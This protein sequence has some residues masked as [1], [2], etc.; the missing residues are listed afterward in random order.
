MQTSNQN[1]D[2]GL[3]IQSQ[4]GVVRHLNEES[5]ILA[6][7]ISRSFDHIRPR[8][9]PAAF[10]RRAGDEA[11]FEIAPGASIVMCWIPSGDFLMGSP[12]CDKYRSHWETQHRVIITKGFW[13]AKT[14]TTQAHWE[15]VMKSNPS[16]VKGSDLPVAGVSWLEICGEITRTE[17]F[18]SKANK[19]APEEFC[20]VLPTE[21][22][23][24]YACRAEMANP[25]LD[26]LDKV[27]WYVENSGGHTHPVGQKKPNSWG[28]HDMIGNIH[29]W[30]SDWFDE[31]PNVTCVDPIGPDSGSYRVYRGGDWNSD[32]AR[33]RIASRF[34]NFPGGGVL[35]NLDLGFRLALCSP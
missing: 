21:A 14:P 10:C 30:C 12:A 32:A 35:R 8:N 18:L 15:A 3:L 29:E 1:K 5:P 4:K 17:G 16:S 33:C 25:F 19:L 34:G 24:E 23:W 27:A 22:Q 31:Y 28:L 2:L 26:A 11:E 7:I 6:E 9:S 20:F 13:L